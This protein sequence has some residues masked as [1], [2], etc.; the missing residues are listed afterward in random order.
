MHESHLLAIGV[1]FVQPGYLTNMFDDFSDNNY[2]RDIR[3]R[4]PRQEMLDLQRH[5]R[6]QHQSR[7]RICRPA[8]SPFPEVQCCD[9][10]FRCIG[11][12]EGIERKRDIKIR[13]YDPLRRRDGLRLSLNVHARKKRFINADSDLHQRIFAPCYERFWDDNRQQCNRWSWLDSG[14]GHFGEHSCRTPLP[15]AAY[16]KLDHYGHRHSHVS[17][18]HSTLAYPS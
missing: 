2:C 17:P 6:S 7:T 18:A 16:P 10:Q 15:F 12:V 1:I 9:S 5:L 4:R 13:I 8:S 3:G 14:I 11:S